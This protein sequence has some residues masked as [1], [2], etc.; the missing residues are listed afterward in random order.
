MKKKIKGAIKKDSNSAAREG[1]MGYNPDPH[2]VVREGEGKSAVE[3]YKK[4]KKR[5]Y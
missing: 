2:S 1:E 4:M 3:I 5:G